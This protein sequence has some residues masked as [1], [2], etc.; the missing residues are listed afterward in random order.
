MVA[1]VRFGSPPP[2]ARRASEP[3]TPSQ[4][5]LARLTHDTA[6]G[7]ELGESWVRGHSLPNHRA[8]IP[9][10]SL[11]AVLGDNTPATWQIAAS[12][13]R[14]PDE[15]LQRMRLGTQPVL[16]PQWLPPIERARQT[17][18]QSELP[19]TWRGEFGSILVQSSDAVLL[20]DEQYNEL[21]GDLPAAAEVSSYQFLSKLTTA[22]AKTLLRSKGIM[23]DDATVDEFIAVFDVD[24]SGVLN[25]TQLTALA[26][27][28]EREQLRISKTKS[29]R[30]VIEREHRRRVAEVRAKRILD[31]N[32]EE[33]GALSQLSEKD[34]ITVEEMARQKADDA[35][36]LAAAG[37]EHGADTALLR[38]V[39]SFEPEFRPGIRKVL[40]A[41]LQA[42]VCPGYP[43]P[44][45]L[46]EP[47]VEAAV[48][49]GQ[50]ALEFFTI[51]LGKPEGEVLSM[52]CKEEGFESVDEIL[53]AGLSEADLRELGLV[54]MKSRKKILQLLAQL[55][56]C[57]HAGVFATTT[58][59]RPGVTILCLRTCPSSV[60]ST[61]QYRIVQ[62]PTIQRS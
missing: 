26:R 14:S 20:G 36:R 4:Q 56:Q 16:D 39:H 48:K 50:S 9:S 6:H 29:G 2:G 54:Q 35:A 44:A 1:G 25:P 24:L 43:E 30:A 15:L 23:L 27:V 33:K 60:L 41:I 17:A 49:L 58:R 11:S 18:Q 57:C 37:A 8:T 55:A 45:P 40:P 3:G 22:E 34:R 38:I 19:E 52:R 62:T 46:S 53:A 32:L 5:H 13:E 42:V 28:L 61:R 7:R 12:P 59:T 51:A 47:H 31:K 10:G 21:L